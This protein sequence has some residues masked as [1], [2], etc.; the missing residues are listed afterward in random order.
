MDWPFIFSIEVQVRVCQGVI[1][2]RSLALSETVDTLSLLPRVEG[3]GVEGEGEGMFY[4]F[5]KSPG[6]GELT[7]KEERFI[8]FEDTGPAQ[9]VCVWR[10]S[11]VSGA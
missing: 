9:C 3:G 6:R 4:C 5:D 10:G 8:Q 7:R 2:D 11:H 1:I